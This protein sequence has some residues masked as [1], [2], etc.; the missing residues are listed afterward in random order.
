MTADEC[1]GSELDSVSQHHVISPVLCPPWHTLQDSFFFNM[2][3]SSHLSS[4]YLHLLPRLQQQQPHCWAAHRS[5]CCGA[6]PGWHWASASLE[7]CDV[8]DGTW[9]PWTFLESAWTW[10]CT[11]LGWLLSWGRKTLRRRC[12]RTRRFHGSCQSSR[13]WNSTWGGR[14]ETGPSRLQKPPPKRLEEKQE[15]ERDNVGWVEGILKAVH[16]FFALSSL[17]LIC[18]FGGSLSMRNFGLILLLPAHRLA[19]MTCMS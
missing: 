13:W 4:S 10:G 2:W 15:R 1:G 3:N 14:C 6:S 12:A 16:W 18:P 11:G 8:A 7:R 19:L 9:P 17:K 5:E